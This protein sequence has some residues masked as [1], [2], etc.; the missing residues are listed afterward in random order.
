MNNNT[1]CIVG[2]TGFVGYH[3][4]S[5]LVEQG[6]KVRILTRHWQRHRNMLLLPGVQLREIDV[7]DISALSN[8]FYDCHT[9]INLAGILNDGLQ[10]GYGYNHVHVTLPEK[11]GQACLDSG[12][13]R[14]F[15]MSALNADSNKGASYYL[16]SKGEGEAQLQ[17]LARQGLQVAIFRPSVIF[18]PGDYFFNQFASLLTYIPFVFPLA[19]PN[20]T[21]SP[22]YVGDVIQA[23]YFVLTEKPALESPYELCGP[24]TYTLQQLVEY[25]AQVMGIKRKIIPLSDAWSL[26]Q[27]AILERFPKKLFSKDN[28]ATLQ[29][30]SV[31]HQNR[32][33]E[34]EITPTL[35]EAIVPKYLIRNDQRENY[36]RFRQRAQRG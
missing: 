31:C 16:R 11:I 8:Q 6:Y 12:I 15:H 13:K 10:S 22:I 35:V 23:I 14:L 33:A 3:L 34:L 27:A 2:G 1:I 20:A 18:G 28:Y 36:F 9:V 21:F 25:T 17:H 4:T 32:L 26:K 5:Y 29:V 30:P 24:N 7:Y 19:C